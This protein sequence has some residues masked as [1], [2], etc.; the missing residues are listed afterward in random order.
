[1]QHVTCRSNSVLH[2]CTK[3][4]CY[5]GGVTS[6]IAPDTQPDISVWSTSCS[7]TAM[8]DDNLWEGLRLRGR[9]LIT[10]RPKGKAKEC[11]RKREQEK[12]CKV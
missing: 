1:M 2:R 6:D 12:I 4:A 7:C 10:Q 8:I 5:F 11:Q 9:A 3:H